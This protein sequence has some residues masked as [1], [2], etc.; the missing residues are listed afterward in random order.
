MSSPTSSP[1]QT[2][3]SPKK[4]SFSLHIYIYIAYLHRPWWA[5]CGIHPR[6]GRSHR[7]WY[8]QASRC[9]PNR[10]IVVAYNGAVNRDG[11]S[12]PLLAVPFTQL[13]DGFF[14]GCSFNHVGS[15]SDG[16]SF[17]NFLN[18][19]SEICRT[20]GG[21]EQISNLPTTNPHRWVLSNSIIREPIIRRLFPEVVALVFF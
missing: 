5:R 16:T 12:L 6:R 10:W 14:I 7:P 1:S 2:T 11:H 3:L 19:W 15:Y 21:R 9:A 18:A 17:W 13:V 20:G 8:H 4:D